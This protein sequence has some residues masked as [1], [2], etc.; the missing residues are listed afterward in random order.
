[1]G[2]GP[3]YLRGFIASLLCRTSFVDKMEKRKDDLAI[4][5]PELLFFP[6]FKTR[7]F[8]NSCQFGLNLGE[9]RKQAW[10]QV[11]TRVQTA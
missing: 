4:T 8:S 2:T 9:I 11:K 10:I 5:D 7:G 1:M 3:M 6:I